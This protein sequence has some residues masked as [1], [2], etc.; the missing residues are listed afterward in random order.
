[1]KLK[2]PSSTQY[3]EVCSEEEWRWLRARQGDA[4]FFWKDEST[5][6]P[7]FLKETG[8]GVAAIFP[9]HHHLITH[10]LCSRNCLF[11][12]Q[13]SLQLLTMMLEHVCVSM[14]NQELAHAILVSRGSSCFLPQVF[15]NRI[16]HSIKRKKS[17]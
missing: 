4:S 1:M 16:K 14:M 8:M 9:A 5:H 11:P 13:I 6:G 3:L 12:P 2:L 17:P 15:D 7:R 10:L